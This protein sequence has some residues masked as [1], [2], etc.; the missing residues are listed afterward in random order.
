MSLNYFPKQMLILQYRQ[1][2]LCKCSDLLIQASVIV[3][4]KNCTIKSV[5]KTRSPSYLAR[6]KDN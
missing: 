3:V 4:V 5:V 1:D 2:D 6:L